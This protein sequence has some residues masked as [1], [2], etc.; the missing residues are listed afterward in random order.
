MHYMN[1]DNVIEFNGITKLD[2]E[3]DRVL[4][5]TKGKLK[6]FLIIGYDTDDEFYFSSTLANA[7]E[8]LWLIELAK[9]QLL[10][11]TS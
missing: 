4:E 5:N 3:P 11:T 7:G 10:E 9:K 6:S 2:L 8:M 1:K